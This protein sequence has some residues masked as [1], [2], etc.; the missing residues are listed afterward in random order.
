MW[1]TEWMNEASSASYCVSG[2]IQLLHTLTRLSVVLILDIR[3]K[4]NV[5]YFNVIWIP[6]LS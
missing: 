5:Y 2:Q 1:L 6:L 3:M 4:V